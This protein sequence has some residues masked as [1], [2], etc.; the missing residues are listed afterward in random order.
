VKYKTRRQAV[1]HSE[2]DGIAFAS[3]ALPAQ[4]SAIY[5]VLDHLNHRLESDWEVERVIDWGAGTGS[6]FWFVFP[7]DLM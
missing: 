3:V 7:L 4:Y 5:S 6:A 2:R 1:L